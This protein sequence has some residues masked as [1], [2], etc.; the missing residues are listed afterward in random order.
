MTIT[1]LDLENIKNG[2]DVC[3]YPQITGVTSVVAKRVE[4]W[5]TAQKSEYFVHL[6]INT[7]HYPSHLMDSFPLTCL[8][9]D[10]LEDAVKK[11]AE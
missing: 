11:Y 6:I 4:Q 2:N 8:S 9:K 7:P 3:F 1:T 10:R 5:A